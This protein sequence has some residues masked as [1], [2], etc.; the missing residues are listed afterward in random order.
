MADFDFDVLARYQSSN[1]ELQ[2]AEFINPGGTVSNAGS[3]EEFELG[4]ELSFTFPSLNGS[5][6]Y[7]GYMDVDGSPRPVALSD[8]G[9]TYYMFI[10]DTFSAGDAPAKLK[11]TEG[12]FVF[13]FL[14]GT[15]I[16][17]E[18]GERA[19]ESLVVGDQVLAADGRL[20]PVKWLGYQRVASRFASAE[21][22]A[23]VRI[24]AKALAHNIPHT[25]LLVSADHGIIIDDLIINA[26]ALVNGTTIIREDPKTLGPFFTYWHIE[27]EGHEVI[28]VNGARAETFTDSLSRHA[29]DNF[30]EYETIYGHQESET[31][32]VRMP[33][34][35]SR[36]QI[37][38]AIMQRLSG[39]AK[40]V[41]EAAFN[42]TA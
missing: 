7:V 26:G 42:E 3:D 37:P 27:T 28:M 41:S 38:Q 24:K 2:K 11:I 33:R 15:L 40:E 13:C 36:R 1:L 25:D 20:V 30:S 34:A 9:D 10:D 32:E 5:G 23:P 31:P 19:V 22:L 18:K 35:M 39:R 12:S 17:T 8:D 4:D 16:A 21:H 14:E 6:A 29:F